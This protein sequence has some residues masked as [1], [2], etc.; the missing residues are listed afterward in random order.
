MA[1]TLGVQHLGIVDHGAGKLA[2]EPVME[3]EPAPAAGD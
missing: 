1:F 2:N 3:P